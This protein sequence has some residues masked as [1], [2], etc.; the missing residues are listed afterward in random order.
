MTLVRLTLSRKTKAMRTAGQHIVR[1]Q[2]KLEQCVLIGGSI[3]GRNCNKEF[4]WRM[5]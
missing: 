5:S 3:C 2:C 1:K 4:D